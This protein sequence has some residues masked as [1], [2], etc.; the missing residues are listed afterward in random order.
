MT[1]DILAR[2]NIR[3]TSVF[4]SALTGH[5]LQWGGNFWHSIQ[6]LGEDYLYVQHTNYLCEETLSLPP[7]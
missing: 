6:I 4:I 1:D 5:Q 7:C 3:K 2:I